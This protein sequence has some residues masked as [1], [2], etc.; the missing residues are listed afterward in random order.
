MTIS[1]WFGVVGVALVGAAGSAQASGG[2]RPTVAEPQLVVSG[3]APRAHR[4]VS[5]VRHGALDRAGMADWTAIYDHDTGVPV[6]M[7][8]PGQPAP[9]A[10]ASPAAAEAW[11]REFLAAHL[12]TLA[13][14]AAVADFVVVANQLSPRGDVRS[15]GFAQYANGIAVLGGAVSVAFKQDRMIMSGSTALPHVTAALRARSLQRPGRLASSRVMSAA[16]AWL[17]SAGHA[18]A[19]RGSVA[20]AQVIV[21]II[22]AR[23]SGAVDIDYAVAEQVTMETTAGEPGRWKVFVDAGTGAA[24]A[25]EAELMFDAGTVMYDVSDRAPAAA[26]ERHPQ[27]APNAIC[28]V[29]G[30]DVTS[31]PD[32]GVTWTGTTPASVLPGLTGPLVAVTNHTGALASTTLALVDGGIVTWSRADDPGADA[33]LSAFVYASQVK[34]FVRL[35]INPQLGYLDSQL[36][37]TVNETPGMCNAYSTGDDL[38][39]FQQTPNVCE[40][41]GRVADIVYHEFG[42]SMHRQSIIPGVGQF[43]GA[44]SEGVG[45]TLAVSI[46]GDPGIGRGFFLDAAHTNEPLRDVDPDIKKI[47]PQDLIG[48]VHNDGEIYGETMWELRTRLQSHLGATAGFDQFLKIYYGTVQRAVDIPSSFAE[49]LAADDDDGDLTNGTPNECDIVAAFHAHGLFDPL[50]TG[51]ISPPVRDG[52]KVS[53]ETVAPASVRCNAPVVQSA[54]MSWRPRGG[55]LA[56]IP[57]T[58]QGTTYRGTIPTQPA[59]TIVEY[60]VKVTLSTGEQAFPANNADPYYQFYVG[61]ATKI[62]CAHFEAG[63]AGAAGWT[64]SA[65]PAAADRWEIGPP[66]GLGGDPASAF[67]GN[68]VLGIA[69]GGDGTYAP[70]MT[71]AAVSPNIDLQ[72]RTK[73]H[74]QYYRWLGV[75]DAVYDQAVIE[76]NGTQ[77]WKNPT[78]SISARS[79]VVAESYN[80]IDREW[81][82][83]DIDL[84]AEAGTGMIQLAFGLTSDPGFE[85]AGWNLDDVCLVATGAVCGNGAIETGEDCDDGNTA[86]GDGCSETCQ[87]EPGGGGGCCGTTTSPAAPMALSAL[88][89]GVV[90]RRR[91]F[92]R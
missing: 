53:I 37:V 7:W 77:I 34:Q 89:L 41:T 62:W 6:R 43:D 38:H 40:N 75:E 4:D 54:A 42:H 83:Q 10:M 8:G 85:A 47:W 39:F 87:D 81:R 26:A 52:F 58:V 72:G 84:S 11:A 33:Q 51:E 76:A 71:T 56:T 28:N 60:S 64:H 22:H 57:L 50:V 61:N 78:S 3:R 74:L 32:G 5:W 25:R 48:E 29:N 88:A 35:H 91:R 17:A 16:A 45:D 14:G 73:V 30:A 9:G 23:G 13:P 24:I 1:T 27:P 59:G 36:S 80:L 49:A 20:A 70:L 63:E 12:E 15:V 86:G 68:N 55:V 67:A 19:A 46:T 82:F 65:T 69:L 21:P 2:A 66:H 44:M 92:A 90:L 18:V 79:A 31:G